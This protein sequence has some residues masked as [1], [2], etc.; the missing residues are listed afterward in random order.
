MPQIPTRS[1]HRLVHNPRQW[2]FPAHFIAGR[3]LGG[4]KYITV[5]ATPATDSSSIDVNGKS[6]SASS[7][8]AT[9]EILGS[10]YSLLSVSLAPSQHLHTRRGTLVG[11]SSPSP[12]GTVSTLRLLTPFRRAL[13]GIPFLYQR[14]TSTTPISALISTPSTH[15]TFAI[16]QL[17]GTTDWRITQRKALLAWTGNSLAVAPV[18]PTTLSTSAYGTSTATGRGLLALSGVGQIYSLTLGPGESYVAHPSNILAYALSS[19]SN[20]PQPYRFKSSTLKFQIPLSLGNWFP[21]P[22]FWRAA[23]ESNTYKFLHNVLRRM[24]TWSRRTIW[25]DRL[26]LRFEGPTTLLIQSRASRIRD[27][28]TSEEVNEIADAPAGLAAEAI[29]DVHDGRDA[30]REKQRMGVQGATPSAEAGK[31]TASASPQAGG[32]AQEQPKLEVKSV[33]EDGKVTFQ[34]TQQP[35]KKG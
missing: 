26:F 25:G 10:P 2:A 12:D 5:Q 15:T 6:L 32:P 23:Q 19:T 14:I 28:L 21:T 31:V 22:A 29:R 33:N 18:L 35:A 17:D 1:L 16:L 20:A 4:Y 24:R 8:D 34:A 7:P 9:F 11:V 27:I 3:R 30:G 13:T